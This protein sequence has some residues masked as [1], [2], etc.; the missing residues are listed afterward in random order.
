M[1]INI[2]RWGD[3]DVIL[4]TGVTAAMLEALASMLQQCNVV[5]FRMPA[6]INNCELNMILSEYQI[7]STNGNISDSKQ[8]VSVPSAF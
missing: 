4:T 7:V 3:S 1:S 2:Y 5:Y 8:E 6:G